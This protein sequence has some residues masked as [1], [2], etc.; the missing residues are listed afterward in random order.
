M[1]MSRFLAVLA[2]CLVC[3][4]YMGE[5]MEAVFSACELV[6]EYFPYCLEFLVGDPYFPFPST[7]C[8]EHVAKLNKLAHSNTGPRTICWCIE[9]MVRGM[10]PALVPSKIQELPVMC[11]TTLS[12]PISDSMDCSKVG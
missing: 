7:R 2:V 11:N 1:A 5:A 12:F 9:V 3:V 4:S 10:T 8:C 6:F